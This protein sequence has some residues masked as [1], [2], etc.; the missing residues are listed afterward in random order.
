LERRINIFLKSAGLLSVAAVLSAQVASVGLKS[1]SIHAEVVRPSDRSVTHALAG[2]PVAGYLVSPG[3][4][5]IHSLLTTS[6]TVKVDQAISIPGVTR[7]VYMPPRQQYALVEQESGEPVAVWTLRGQP[8]MPI[9]GAMAHP[10]LV[11]FSPRG[12]A[13]ILYSQGSSSLQ[14]ITHLPAEPAVSRVLAV[15]FSNFEQFAVSDDGAVVVALVATGRMVQSSGSPAWIPLQTGFNAR[16][17]CF[18]PKTRNL[19]IADGSQKVIAELSNVDSGSVLSYRVLAQDVEANQ[20]LATRGGEVLVAASLEQG[21]VWTVDLRSGAVLQ[22]QE[23]GKISSL[24]S[25]R[26][27]YT[28]LLANSDGLSLMRLAEVIH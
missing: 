8:L 28:F 25:L 9:G 2:T 15:P 6:R 4:S 14:V 22:K 21:E 24:Y 7:R 1:E 10:D 26:D 16:A 12:D 20:L 3:G 27:G 19:A 17:L 13:M 5:E 11:A 18:I 23:A